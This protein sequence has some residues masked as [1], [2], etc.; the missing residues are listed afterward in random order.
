MRLE[1][2]EHESNELK[3]HSKNTRVKNSNFIIFYLEKTASFN[4]ILIFRYKKNKIKIDKFHK[5]KFFIKKN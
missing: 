4:F 2:N 3:M 5:N 1:F